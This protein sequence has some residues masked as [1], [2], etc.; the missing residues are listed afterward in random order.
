[1]SDRIYVR[2]NGKMEELE[3]QPFSDEQE[4]VL[5]KL[6]A[7]HPDLLSGS[8]IRPDD[9]LRWILITREQGIPE[10]LG[11]GN[12]WSVDHLLIDQE[13]RPTLVETKLRKNPEIRRTVVGQLLEYAAHAR[14]SW[15]ADDL[16]RTFE[17][18]QGWEGLLRSLLGEEEPGADEFWRKVK[19]NL[20]ASNLRLLFVADEIPDSLARIVEFLNEQMR[21]VDVLAVEVKRYVGGSRETFVPRVIGR[22]AKPRA[23]NAGTSTTLA[24]IIAAFPEGAVRDAARQ[25]MDRAKAAGASFEPG[26]LGTSIRLPKGASRLLDRPITLAW[27]YP[28]EIGNRI[29]FRGTKHFTFGVEKSILDSEPHTELHDAL[30][31]Y[32]AQFEANAYARDL[33]S[34]TLSAWW[35][36]PED[37][38]ANIGV[39]CERLERV[40]AE[41]RT[42]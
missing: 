14:R 26:S 22:S 6:I 28:Q 41:L 9:P 5:Q 36:A 38:A 24:D 4:D 21:D 7:E 11:A 15:D 31:A 12:R 32:L 17:A 19:T 37:T 29:G 18:Q 8:Q 23:S 1:M 42:L 16:R 34:P 25:L 33:D 3:E 27:V 10:E 20:R 40:L 30:R 35:V 13:A 2:T 39:L